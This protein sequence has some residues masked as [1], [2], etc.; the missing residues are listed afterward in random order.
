M[1][2]VFFFFLGWHPWHMEVPRLGVESELQLLAYIT[3]TATRDPGHVCD[4]HQSSRQCWILNPLSRTR[5]WNHILMDTSQVHNPLSYNWNSPNSILY[6][7]LALL[8]EFVSF[9]QW[10][11]NQ[12][13][14]HGV[15]FSLWGTGN[16]EFLAG[17]QWA[18]D[19]GPLTPARHMVSRGHE[20][21]LAS[22]G[23]LLIYTGQ[24]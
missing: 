19:W 10:V 23:S 18:E 2:T 15:C 21:S 24:P 20:C 3:V 8:V 7:S 4:L 6:K 9:V 1:P 11:E 22:E 5:D 13:K 16:M 17:N 14:E 12:C